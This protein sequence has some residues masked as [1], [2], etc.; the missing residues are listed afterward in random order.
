MKKPNN[1]ICMS[2]VVD[3]IKPECR[4]R[5]F[6]P[7][8]DSSQVRRPEVLPLAERLHREHPNWSEKKCI[9]EAKLRI[10]SKKA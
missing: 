8:F 3:A 2:G 7:V 1:I 6:F 9:E 10:T 5:R 4:D